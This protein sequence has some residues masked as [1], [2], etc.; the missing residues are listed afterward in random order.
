M[1]ILIITNI[2]TL[3]TILL[4]TFL[5]LSLMLKE[6]YLMAGTSYVLLIMFIIWVFSFVSKYEKLLKDQQKSHE[7]LDRIEEKIKELN[8]QKCPVHYNSRSDELNEAM[9]RLK[10]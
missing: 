2:V 9:M 8:K 6:E 3:I 7:I 1:N 5:F 4:D 10:D